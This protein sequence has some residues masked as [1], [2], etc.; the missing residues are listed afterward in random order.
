MGGGTLSGRG[1]SRGSRARICLKC[2]ERGGSGQ[3]LGKR[4]GQSPPTGHERSNGWKV[5]GLSRPQ[6]EGWGHGIGDH[7]IE[8]AKKGED[9]KRETGRD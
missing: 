1:E 6:K 2:E 9:G 5:N 8:C 7:L 4:G 3:S